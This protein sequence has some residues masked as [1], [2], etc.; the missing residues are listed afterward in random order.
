VSDVLQDKL[1][2]AARYPG[3]IPVNVRTQDLAAAVGAATDGWGADVVFEASGNPAAF[4]GLF[5]LVRPG[6]CVVLIGIPIDPVAFDVA[7]AQ[8][9]EVRLETVF[10]YANVYPRAIALIASGKIDL[11]P[12]ISATFAFEDSIKAFERAVEGR[13]SDVKLQIRVGAG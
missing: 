11:K 1:D 7:G 5:G 9:K 13:G 12:L 2:I 6:G 4:K 3:I 10:R 8:S